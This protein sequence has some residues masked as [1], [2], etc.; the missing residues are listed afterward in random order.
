MAYAVFDPRED[1]RNKVG[2]SHF[3]YDAD[4]S[5][6]SVSN[7]IED[8]IWVPML[9]PSEVRGHG[10]MYP[11]PFI[12]MVLVSSTGE[13]HNIGGDRRYDTA[14]IDF[15]LYFT[16]V[17]GLTPYTFEKDVLNK[18]YNSTV[19]Y[20]NIVSSCTFIEPIQ[21][22]EITEFNENKQLV[23]HYVITC[24]GIQYQ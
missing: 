2:T 14:L 8:T 6:V 3:L 11:M 21:V 17:D 1:F 13:T 22:R 24:R 12:E 9:F 20:R 7:D 15:N 10:E 23:Y 16:D 19:S 5:C 4:V 18:I